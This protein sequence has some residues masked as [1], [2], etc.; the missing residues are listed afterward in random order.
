MTQF[1]PLA[2]A[3]LSGAVVQK[4][5]AD[6]K[7]QQIRRTQLVRSNAATQADTFEPHVESSDELHQTDDR[8]KKGS[9]PRDSRRPKKPVPPPHDEVEHNHIDLCG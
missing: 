2:A 9:N 8:H 6:A 1:N 7:R 3:V 5:S 4:Q